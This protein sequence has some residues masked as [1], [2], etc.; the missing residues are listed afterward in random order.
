MVGADTRLIARLDLRQYTTENC[1]MKYFVTSL[2]NTESCVLLS[3]QYF[4]PYRLDSDILLTEAD[5]RRSHATATLWCNRGFEQL[6][7][8]LKKLHN[9]IVWRNQ[10]PFDIASR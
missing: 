2:S 1:F 7:F 4:V 3:R 8:S 9:P 10:V 5:K 6:L